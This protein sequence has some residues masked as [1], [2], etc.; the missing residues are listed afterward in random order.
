MPGVRAML[1]GD[2]SKPTTMYISAPEAAAVVR[3]VQGDGV[4]THGAQGSRDRA[5]EGTAA[6]L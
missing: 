2:T 4:N 3:A 6:W 5:V 1:Q